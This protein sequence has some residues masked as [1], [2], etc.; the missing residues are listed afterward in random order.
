MIHINIL[1]DNSFRSFL[2]QLPKTYLNSEYD[3]HENS[4]LDI[5]WDMVVVYDG[6]PQS[7]IIKC[8]PGGMVFISGEPPN[9]VKFAKRFLSQFD[10]LI[11][12]NANIQHMNN[13]QSQPALDWWFGRNFKTK[14]YN[15]DFNKIDNLPLPKKDR[16]ISFISS[17]QSNFPGHIKRLK[18]LNAVK[19]KF[20]NQVDFFGKGFNEVEDKADALLRYK[21]SICIENSEILHYWTEKIADPFL[22]YTVP[23]Y[24]GC[25][26]ILEYFNL[27]SL[28]LIDINNI[29]E[30][31][32]K[33]EFIL[34]NAD[35]IYS[36][37]I[38]EIINS[39]KKLLFE[40]NIFPF[41]SKF[42]QKKINI[43]IKINNLSIQKKLQLESY[44]L[45]TYI[46]RF[47][48]KN[49]NFLLRLPYK[50]LNKLNLISY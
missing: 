32:S 45:E 33:I 29:P 21:F 12:T 50:I 17:N 28:E 3:F 30:S 36:K 2:R 11:T 49:K 47:F 7:I 39:R 16:K 48:L 34:E 40:Y 23:I 13:H 6:I 22:A 38:D 24:F 20:G 41:L 44:Y 37:K 26:N 46:L 5:E 10:H 9:S 15:L 1:T 42:Y 43:D 25:Q 19:M 4:L 18:F 8:K 14:K 27:K 31:L 35:K